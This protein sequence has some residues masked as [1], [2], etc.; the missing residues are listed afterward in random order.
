[1]VRLVITDFSTREDN[2]AFYQAEEFDSQI[3][4]F[5][6]NSF[7]KHGVY[8]S[9]YETNDQIYSLNL[10]SKK[11][12][13]KNQFLI[14]IAE[15]EFIILFNHKTIYSAKISQNFITD[16]MIKSILITKHVAMLSS[17]GSID[18]I[19][20]VI[21]SRYKSAIENILK[22]NTRNENGDVVAQSLGEI[23]DLVKPLIELDTF[24]GT[25]YKNTFS[26]VFVVGIL[27]V[28]FFGLNMVTNKYLGE[29]SLDKL[30]QDLL[31]ENRVLKRQQILYEKSIKEYRE[32]TDCI[33][34]KDT[35]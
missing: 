11:H 7:K 20:Y 2:D 26:L 15:G 10:L 34:I 30:Q 22:Q 35:K 24:N 19:Y 4:M 23:K 16:D 12:L 32:L 29:N 28:M 27:W 3:Q 1:M 5:V 25:M 6:Y 8:L 21:N 17:G 9:K 14:H 31:V 33:T 18:K 13:A